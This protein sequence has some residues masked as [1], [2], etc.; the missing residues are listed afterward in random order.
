M[1]Q[2]IIISGVIFLQITLNVFSFFYITQALIEFSINSAILNK[3]NWTILSFFELFFL[4]YL[5]HK[6]QDQME[7]CTSLMQ[8]DLLGRNLLQK[9]DMELVLLQISNQKSPFTCKYFDIDMML[10]H[11]VIN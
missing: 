2:L 8:K 1:I 10:L 4:C 6:A 11:A 9:I 5:T 3:L 7:K